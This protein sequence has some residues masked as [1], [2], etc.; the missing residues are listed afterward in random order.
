MF[1]QINQYIL[2]MSAVVPV[3]LFIFLGSIL[4]DIIAPIPSPLVTTAAGSI[5][6]AQGYGY[7]GLVWLALIAACGKIIGALVLYFIADKAEDFL[8]VRL[9][10]KIGVSHKHIEEYGR[11]FTGSPK[12]YVILT[13]IR[14]LPIIP[15]LPVSVVAGIIKLPMKLY[16]IGTFVGSFLRSI[17][18]IVLGYVGLSAYQQVIEGID[19]IESIIQIAIVLALGGLVAWFYYKRSRLNK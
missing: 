5:A 12:D 17:L 7:L 9:G 19:S 10:P 6:Q 15:A 2:S 14:A 3:E 16:I 1:E 4:E 8:L 18:F 13:V 11:R